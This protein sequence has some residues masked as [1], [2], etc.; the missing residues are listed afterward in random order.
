[1]RSVF[2]ERGPSQPARKGKLK[3]DVRGGD[4]G[5]GTLAKVKEGTQKFCLI[6]IPTEYGKNKVRKTVGK[7]TRGLE[8]VPRQEKERRKRGF[9]SL[10]LDVRWKIKGKMNARRADI[11]NIIRRECV[12]SRLAPSGEPHKGGNQRK[13]KQTENSDQEREKTRLA[14][15]ATGNACFKHREGVKRVLRGKVLRGVGGGTT[16]G[17]GPNQRR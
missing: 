16:P 3:K 15:F 12:D 13:T 17:F 2:C 8:K 5:D 6:L 14:R 1:M 10:G 11:W 4:L 7:R 9:Q